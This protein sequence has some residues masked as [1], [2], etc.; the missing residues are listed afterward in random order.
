MCGSRKH[1]Y[2]SYGWMA[3]GN[4]E[5]VGGLKS[6]NFKGKFE[7]KKEF[8]EGWGSKQRRPSTE[9]GGGGG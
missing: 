2:P 9:R 1:P 5:G 8:L 4:F 6:Q 3:I 7:A